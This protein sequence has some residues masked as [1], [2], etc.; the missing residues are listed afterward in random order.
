MESPKL[1]LGTAVLL[2]R[3]AVLLRG[4]SGCGKSS[5][6]LTLMARDGACFPVRL[7]AD[8][9]V[10]ART[11]GASVVMTPPPATRGMVE[12]RGVGLRKVPFVGRAVLGLVVD[13]DAG[14]AERLPEGA[15]CV[16]QVCGIE[17]P[18]VAIDPAGASA[19]DTVLAV[20]RALE[21]GYRPPL[22][23][24]VADR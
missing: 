14:A 4:P 15:D 22:L 8:D 2:G 18:R 19:A 12:I 6:A 5:L 24:P 16:A 20:A 23:D 7:V 21:E 1:I 11:F 3:A 10:H 9:A 13:L 17:V